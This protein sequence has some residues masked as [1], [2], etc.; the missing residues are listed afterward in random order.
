MATDFPS[1]QIVDEKTIKLLVQRRSII[2]A[3]VGGTPVDNLMLA[4]VLNHGY[5]S[6]VKVWLEDILNKRVGELYFVT[7]CQLYSQLYNPSLRLCTIQ[8]TVGAVDLLLHLLNCIASLPV[9]KDMVNSSG[10]GKL[11]GSIDR[12]PIC[13]GTPNENVIKGRLTIVKERWS[14]SVKIIKTS[15]S[16]GD[17]TFVSLITVLL[18]SICSMI[19]FYPFSRIIVV[20]L[21]QISVLLLGKMR[22]VTS[23]SHAMMISADYCPIWSRRSHLIAPTL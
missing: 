2:L 4:A 19:F 21:L 18:H 16:V 7:R 3:V 1:G 17:S 9:S 6:T 23:K 13:T 11:I 14:A 22:T 12:H 5:L 8:L 10:L 20:I 15:V